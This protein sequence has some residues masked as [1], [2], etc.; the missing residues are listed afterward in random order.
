[1]RPQGKQD[2]YPV[3]EPLRATL[4]RPAEMPGLRTGYS[5]TWNEKYDRIDATG[6]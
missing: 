2:P 4:P 1:M 3:K 6:V 5:R